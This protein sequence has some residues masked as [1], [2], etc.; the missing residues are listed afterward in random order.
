MSKTVF[1]LEEPVVSIAG[2]E[3][4]M[5]GENAVFVA[6][7]TNAKPYCWSL[8]WQKTIENVTEI[9]NITKDKY[10]GST[11]RR[12]VITAVSKEDEWRYQAVLSRNMNGN[13]QKILS[14]E[15]FLQVLG[16]IFYFKV[17]N[18]H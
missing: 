4:A 1:V 18:Y 15:I 13:K 17:R 3:N 6:E 11:D 16:G 9:I 14:N 2:N 8:T 5:C 10:F 7:V 12:L